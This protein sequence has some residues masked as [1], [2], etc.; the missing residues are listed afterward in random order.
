MRVMVR[1]F[2][3]VRD[4]AGAGELLREVP[5]GC[6]VRDL[7]RT[8]IAEF[9]ALEPYSGS[10]SG[11]RNLEYVRMDAPLAD[12]DEVAFLP[13]VSGGKGGGRRPRRGRPT[14]RR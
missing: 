8:L 3:R 1:L 4:I 5:E 7:W 12:G 11:A 14:R 13:P 2:A 10:V 9:P 6:T